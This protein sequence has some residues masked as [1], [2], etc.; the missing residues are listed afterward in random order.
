MTWREQDHPRNPKNGEF[1]GKGTG[2]AKRAADALGA[3]RGG[4]TAE[5]E[6]QGRHIPAAAPRREKTDSAVRTLLALSHGAP[7]DQPADSSVAGSLAHADAR[8]QAED[9]IVG[10]L[11]DAALTR[12]ELDD[13]GYQLG[14]DTSSIR[15]PETKARTIARSLVSSA[16]RRQADPKLQRLIQQHM[17][18]VSANQA[19]YRQHPRAENYELAERVSSTKRAMNEH[20]QSMASG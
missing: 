18:A 8:R 7:G 13:V 6:Q 19:W 16:R 1:V 2:W 5:M 3:G 17:R 20:I 11:D 12:A 15:D 14:V 10:H 9:L 4:R